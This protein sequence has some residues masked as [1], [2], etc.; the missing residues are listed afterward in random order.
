MYSNETDI[1]IQEDLRLKNQMTKEKSIK[2]IERALKFLNDSKKMQEKTSI[3]KKNSSKKY[4]IKK[5]SIDFNKESDIGINFTQIINKYVEKMLTTSQ[6]FELVKEL[7]GVLYDAGYVTS[8]IGL[9]NKDLSNSELQFIIHWGYIDKIYINN[10]SPQSYRDKIM[11]MILPRFDNN[12]IN[13]KNIDQMIEILNTQNKNAKINVIASKKKGYS[14]LDIQLERSYF[15]KFQLGF[16][17]SGISSNGKYQLTANI[18][19][20]DLLG[21][22][23]TWTLSGTHRFFKNNDVNSQNNY[24]IN[25]IQPFSYYTLNVNFSFF[26]YKKQLIGNISNYNS[27]GSTKTLNLKLTKV[28]FRNKNTILSLYTEFE[29][30]KNLSYLAKKLISNKNYNKV[31]FGF[32]YLVNLYSGSLFLDIYYSHGLKLLNGEYTAYSGDNDKNLKIISS[33]LTWNKYFNIFSRIFNYQLRI[34]SQYSIYSLNDNVKFSIGDEYTVR[35]FKGSAI[36]GDSGIYISNT[37]T[38]PFYPQ[39]KYLT[40]VFPF[41]GFDV[42]KIYENNLH[43]QKNIISGIALGISMQISNFYFSFIYSK[44]LN[45]IFNDK[46][47]V[48]YG[49]ITLSI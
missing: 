8:A 11:L 23:D 1:L 5:I 24:K 2:E 14:N 6:I 33:N 18:S 47:P 9:K 21:I 13:I 39:Y 4:Y 30:K 45:V 27:A 37:L 44:P 25:Y 20:S 46:M 22:N 19:M 29:Y 3:F 12:L 40:F 41:L 10:E 31:N 35:G 36:S 34:G 28:I 16:N 48:Y 17:N 15:P 42:G 32:S 49:N 38:I 43:N 7:T 26:Y